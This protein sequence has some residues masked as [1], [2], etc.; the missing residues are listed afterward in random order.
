MAELIIHLTDSNY[1][2]PK[3]VAK[4]TGKSIQV[5]IC[6]WISQLPEIENEFDITKDPI[7]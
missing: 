7:F 2:R 1:E 4:K 3:E 5:L 6:E